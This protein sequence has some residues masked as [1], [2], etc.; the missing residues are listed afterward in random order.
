M[1]VAGMLPWGEAVQ[2]KLDADARSLLPEGSGADALSLRIHKF[3][4]TFN[5]GLCGAAGWNR[6]QHEE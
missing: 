6:N 5:L 2:M 4:F 1:E 3:N